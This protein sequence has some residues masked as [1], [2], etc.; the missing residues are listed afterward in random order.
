MNNELEA[1]LADCLD[2]LRSGELTVEDCLEQ[3]PEH[4]AEL[5]SLLALADRLSD[6]SAVQPS[7]DFRRAARTRLIPKLA[8]RA[9]AAVTFS[10][11]LR[12][13]WAK[14]K[15]PTLIRRPRMAWVVVVALVVALTGGG[16]VGLVYAADGSSPGS[17]L[18]GVDRAVESLRF[19]LA[20]SPEGRA[21][22]AMAFAEERLAELE[23]LIGAD[24]SN[25]N[26]QQAIDGYGENI[27]QAA[28]ALAV[29]AATNDEARAEALAN[30]L[31][32]ALSVHDEVLAEVQERVPEQAKDQ[33]GRAIDA[34]QAAMQR[35]DEIFADGMPGGPPDETPGG[36]P[37][38]A[39]G[40]PPGVA[41]GVPDDPS[42]GPPEDLGP[43]GDVPD[44]ESRVEGLE[45]LIRETRDHVDEGDDEAAEAALIEYQN[46][47]AA[48][49]QELAAAARDDT[50]RAEALAALLAEALSVHGEILTQVLDQVPEQAADAIENAI[51][52]SEAG[53]AMIQL[54]FG[55][56]FPGGM[57]DGLTPEPPGGSS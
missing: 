47:V 50:D 54:L 18:Y 49:A 30:L 36:P 52:R 26:I 46:E 4:R 19:A 44:F 35:L 21:E 23:D 22:L 29:V 12:N 10:D 20:R 38:S 3:Y 40:G 7:P 41:P 32:Q 6:A 56:G 14:P 28:Q 9:L 15:A 55:D 5:R 1:I 45:D 17:P 27:S 24:G 31:Q 42:E 8:P 16:G 48:L 11:R 34:S 51:A 43:D 25:A 53:L 37:D 13:L 57:P 39:A 2:G 33:V